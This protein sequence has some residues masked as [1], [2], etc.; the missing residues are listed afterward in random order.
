MVFFYLI[1]LTSNRFEKVVDRET[2][3]GDE[4]KWSVLHSSSLPELLITLLLSHRR[5]KALQNLV[6]IYF[7][8]GDN[9]K[10][11]DRYRTMLLYM[12]KVTRNECTDAIN[13]ILDTLQSA[14]SFVGL[15][16]SEVQASSLLSLF[17]LSLL[18]AS[19]LSVS[20]CHLDV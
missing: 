9:S 16:L 12:T 5:F 7:S 20:L 19:L 2:S 4:V 17:T 6:T 3:R 1:I 11:I 13:I 10:M 18:H 14:P 15:D 8:L